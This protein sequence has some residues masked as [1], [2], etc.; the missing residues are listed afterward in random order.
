[1]ARRHS[2]PFVGCRSGSTPRPQD[3]FPAL[4]GMARRRDRGASAVAAIAGHDTLGFSELEIGVLLT[5]GGVGW[6]LTGLWRGKRPLDDYTGR[7]TLGVGLLVAGLVAMAAATG[8]PGGLPVEA[9]T[10]YIIGW[11]AVDWAWG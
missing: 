9:S 4:L 8:R 3:P 1:M 10:A 2:A 11:G 6:A 7:A 5:V